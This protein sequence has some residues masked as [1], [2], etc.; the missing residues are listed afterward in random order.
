MVPVLK[1]EWIWSGWHVHDG[2][3]QHS[4]FLKAGKSIGDPELRHM[5]TGATAYG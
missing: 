5:G 1:D 4:H 3:R 2:K